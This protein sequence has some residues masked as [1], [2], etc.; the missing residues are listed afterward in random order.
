MVLNPGF[1]L[2]SNVKYPVLEDKNNLY[3]HILTNKHLDTLLNKDIF[4]EGTVLEKL[5]K[6]SKFDKSS[7]EYKMLYQDI[8]KVGEYKI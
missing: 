8:I 7:H 2:I 3:K 6:L 4:Y 1:P 5:M